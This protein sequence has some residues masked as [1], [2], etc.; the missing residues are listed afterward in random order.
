MGVADVV[1]SL[2]GRLNE[3][4]LSCDNKQSI[5]IKTRV[6]EKTEEIGIA[7]C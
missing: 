6:S 4:R 7:L 5:H 1:N 2:E 3:I